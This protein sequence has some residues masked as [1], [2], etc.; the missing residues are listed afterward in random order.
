M[1]K[2]KK[3]LYKAILL[4]LLVFVAYATC[5]SVFNIYKPH[6]RLMP[7]III[8]G[9]IV[10]VF[11]FIFL[12][13]KINKINERTS[14]VL[15]IIICVIFFILMSLF[16]N[17]LGTIPSSDIVYL[18]NE[19]HLMMENGGVFATEDYF[20]RYSY[21]TPVAI[22]VYFI[23][24]TGSLFHIENLAA[25]GTVI[26]AL[27]I[28]ITAAFTYLTIKSVK[29][30]QTALITL[31]FFVLNPIFYL[32]SS[33]FYTDTLC[34]PF[35]AIAMYLFVLGIKKDKKIAEIM[36][37]GTS[38]ILLA[39][40]TKIR[41]VICIILIAMIM[42]IWFKNR[43]CK[44]SIINVVTLFIGFLIGWC[45][46]TVIA[47]PFKTPNIESCK[48]PSTYWV[49]MGL[50]EESDGKYIASDRAYVETRELYKD[51]YYLTLDEIKNRIRNFGV[52]GLMNFERNKI[53][54]NWS[55][56]DY[57]YVQKLTN[58][59]KINGLYKYTVGNK[60]IFV[61][62]YAQICKAFIMV[63][64]LIAIIKELYQ[65]D[66]D[67]N[68]SYLFISMIGAFAFYLLWE[69]AARY[70]LTFLPWMILLF[71][72]GLEGVEDLLNIYE[73]KTRDKIIRIISLKKILA[74]LTIV[75][76]LLLMIIN[77]ILMVKVK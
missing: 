47:L 14:N 63:I 26:N 53:S 31:L 77:F 22:L 32:Y 66:I 42:S 57:D 11:F 69:V 33:Y 56:G 74:V 48:L 61:L 45:I 35:A 65:K 37:L 1:E 27:F 23:Y 38:G 3:Y 28:A 39:I 76:S 51:K 30:H 29:N 2:V 52:T 58:V 9:V 20:S 68:N 59:E 24:R 54:V 55:N 60:N 71:G 4:V 41:A 5:C 8:F 46:C 70:S 40:G 67:K 72:S 21:Q 6:E 15:A 43:I 44:K 18:R 16:G 13:R 19:A 73:I 10:S 75:C 49:M 62:Y 34:M 12:K 50:N 25:F 64:F 17:L 36:L 7:I